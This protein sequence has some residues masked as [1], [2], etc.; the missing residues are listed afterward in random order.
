MQS[1]LFVGLSRNVKRVIGKLFKHVNILVNW[2]VNKR[3]HLCKALPQLPCL[4]GV[5]G[6]SDRPTAAETENSPLPPARGIKLV[7][8]IFKHTVNI[9]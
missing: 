2:E 8:T 9:S 3:Q 7:I 1:N 5:S 4:S 6:A